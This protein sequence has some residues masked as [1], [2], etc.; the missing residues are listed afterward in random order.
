MSYLYDHRQL[1]DEME[2]FFFD[3]QIGPGLP[4]WL[5]NGVFIRDQ[6]ESFIKKLEQNLGYQRVV[7]PHL[8]KADL[9]QRSG[10]LKA[11]SENMYPPMKWPEDN[12]DYY[13][14]PMN[15]PHHHKVFASSP[16]SYRHLPLRIAE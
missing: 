14:K 12:S 3:D 7:S 10:H 6:L 13:L 9:Y 11:F 5:P 15:C 2:I 16:R 4:V 8:A 1:A